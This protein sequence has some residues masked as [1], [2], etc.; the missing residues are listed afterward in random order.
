MKADLTNFADEYLFFSLLRLFRALRSY[1][2]VI[3][4]KIT[5]FKINIIKKN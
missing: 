3:S 5:I 2:S 4:S 1:I